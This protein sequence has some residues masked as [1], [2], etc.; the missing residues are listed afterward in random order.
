MP[1]RLVPAVQN[2]R[3]VG[4]MV[5]IPTA[6]PGSPVQGAIPPSRQPY[7]RC[8]APPGMHTS[9]DPY[10]PQ[11]F[12]AW[13]GFDGCMRELRELLERSLQTT[14]LAPHIHRPFWARSINPVTRSVVNVPLAFDPVAFAAGVAL[15]AAESAFHA[16]QLLTPT[17]A[18]PP[19]EAVPVLEFETPAGNV[20][21][22]KS[23]GVTVEVGN[24]TAARVTVQV[25][26]GPNTGTL[27][28]NPLTSSAEHELQQSTLVILP[29]NKRFQ[30]LVQ[31][32][33]TGAPILVRAAWTGWL[34]PIREWRMSLKSMIP[35]PGYGPTCQED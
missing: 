17:N 28:P 18:V 31:N 24:E 8:L 14:D 16:V 5:P 1:V 35:K 32:L 22:V 29:E 20:A 19:F 3:V 11:G 21:V 25:G 26:G 15:A 34:L 2:G 9:V 30:I 4:A 10:H 13:P 23:W 12:H 27:P 7:E 33:D 6:G